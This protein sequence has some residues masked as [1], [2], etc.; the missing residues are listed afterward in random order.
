MCIVAALAVAAYAQ[1][2]QP[3]VIVLRPDQLGG[4]DLAS[5]G[6][7][8]GTAGANNPGPTSTTTNTAGLQTIT[9]NGQRFAVVPIPGQQGSR[10]TT[11]TTV[12]ETASAPPP[13]PPLPVARA[14]A[15]LEEDEEPLVRVPYA[16]NYAAENDDGSA[17]AREES[18]DESGTVRGFYTV[19]D[20][21]GR[22][23]RVEYVADANGFRATVITNEIGTE[24]RDPANVSFQ[25]SAPTAAELVARAEEERLRNPPPTTSRPPIRVATTS[26]STNQ[27]GSGQGNVIVLRSNQLQGI[28]GQTLSLPQLLNAQGNG[29]GRLTI[30]RAP[31]GSFR[32]VPSASPASSSRR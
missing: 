30:E 5:L 28:G 27:L 10:S 20:P 24:S 22:S 23:R 32:L 18:S 2:Q 31:D 29:G 7:Q 13:P 25:S 9:R 26:T 21:D 8:G 6:I 4:L 15:S 16:F 11:T 19:T 12:R 14:S 1:Q 17:H 3:R